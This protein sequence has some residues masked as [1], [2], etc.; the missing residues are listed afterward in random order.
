MNTE[1]AIMQ[2]LD[3]LTDDTLLERIAAE[4][5][6]PAGTYRCYKLLSELCEYSDDVILQA[7]EYMAAHSDI[8]ITPVVSAAL[9]YNHLQQ[10]EYD[11]DY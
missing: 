3:A 4:V 5:E 10:E 11:G 2:K 9:L 8:D 7:I 6:L 1:A